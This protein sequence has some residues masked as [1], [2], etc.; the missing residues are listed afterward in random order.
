MSSDMRLSRSFHPP[1][2]ARAADRRLLGQLQPRAMT[3]CREQQGSHIRK[4]AVQNAMRCSVGFSSTRSEMVSITSTDA[5][6]HV[7]AVLRSG[8]RGGKT[9]LSTWVVAPGESTGEALSFPRSLRQ[10]DF[11]LRTAGVTSSWYLRWAFLNE[12]V[13]LP[14]TQH[15]NQ[16]HGPSLCL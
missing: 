11:C 14:S 3:P 5:R 4:H 15:R 1:S 6:L 2:S 10:T 9:G 8:V 12:F 13:I 7:V 16:N